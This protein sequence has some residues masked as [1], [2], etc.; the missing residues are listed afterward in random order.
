MLSQLIGTYYSSRLEKLGYDLYKLL[1]YLPF[2]LEVISPNLKSEEGLIFLTGTVS[3][4]VNK[5]KFQTFEFKDHNLLYPVNVYDFG[6]KLTYLKNFNPTSQYQIL[7]TK[8][9]TYYNLQ[10]IATLTTLSDN[11]ELGSLKRKDYYKPVYTQLAFNLRSKQLNKIYASLPSQA[12]ILDLNGLVP[13]NELI[14]LQLDMSRIHKPRSIEE[15]ND[16]LRDWNNFQAFLNL[17]FLN[18]LNIYEKKSG[19]ILNKYPIGFVDEFQK[20]LNINLSSS[21]TTAIEE[22]LN[23][24]TVK[25][26]I[27]G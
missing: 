21:Q 9:T 22:I 26:D 16:G 10:E 5:G 8:S 25:E 1:T 20:N 3:N 6:K 15:Y 12:M 7:I 23:N 24:I 14:P 27:K 17:V 2:R 18:N 4:I 19:A 13:V 11:Y